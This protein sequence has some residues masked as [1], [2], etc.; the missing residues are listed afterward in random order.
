[1]KALFSADVDVKTLPSCGKW[2][3]TEYAPSQRLV[4]K[5]NP[6]YWEKDENGNSIPYMEQMVF[7]IVGDMNTDY[8]LFKQE[9][10]ES[11]LATPEN[12]SDVVEKSKGQ[13]HCVQCRGKHGGAILEF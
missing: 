4:F 1:M 13:L 6:Y 2:Y 12:V 5:R 3:L 9:K 8:L 10:T 11:Y 7:Q